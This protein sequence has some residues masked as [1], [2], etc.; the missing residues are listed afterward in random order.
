MTNTIFTI[1]RKGALLLIRPDGSIQK[2]GI[3]LRG[4]KLLVY[5]SRC[6]TWVEVPQTVASRQETYTIEVKHGSQHG[7]D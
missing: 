7:N 6:S 2:L 1:G 5:D 3:R 4:G